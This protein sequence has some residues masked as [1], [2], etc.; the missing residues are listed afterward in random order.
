[1]PLRIRELS[2]FDGD[3]LNASK[4]KF[5]MNY[6][7]N[8]GKFNLISAD[9][10]QVE[11]ALDSDISDPFVEQLEKEIDVDNIELLGNTPVDGGTF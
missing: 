4:N 8:N 1:M 3:P 2:D 7:S 5:I 9:N 6:E 10:A 11:A